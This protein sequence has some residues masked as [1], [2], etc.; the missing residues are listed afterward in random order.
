MFSMPKRYGDMEACAG[1]AHT[2]VFVDLLGFLDFPRRCYL[3]V[4]WQNLEGHV[5]DMGVSVS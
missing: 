5:K 3:I 1:M 4:H 2:S